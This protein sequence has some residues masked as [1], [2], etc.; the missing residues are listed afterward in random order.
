VERVRMRVVQRMLHCHFQGL[1]ASHEP[2]R[3]KECVLIQTV[4]LPPLQFKCDAQS[5]REGSADDKYNID[6][7]PVLGGSIW[8]SSQSSVSG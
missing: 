7:I 2:G 6:A 8:Q 5:L 1:C 3:M 4:F